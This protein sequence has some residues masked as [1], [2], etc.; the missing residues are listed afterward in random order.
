LEYYVAT[1]EF[2]REDYYLAQ[3]AAQIERGQV[4]T[5]S[6]V[7]IQKKLLEFTSTKTVK[8]PVRELDEDEED[9]SDNPRVQTSKNFWMGLTGGC[10]VRK[11]PKRK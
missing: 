3:I 1:E 5:P 4:K 11:P 8:E 9:L 10:R 7:T 2:R 6:R